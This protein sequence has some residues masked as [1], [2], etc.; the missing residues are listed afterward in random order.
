MFTRDTPVGA[1]IL[2]VWVFAPLIVVINKD[3]VS[4]ACVLYGP[5]GA[6]NDEETT[7]MSETPVLVGWRRCD[8][9]LP[10]KQPR[11]SQWVVDTL[12]RR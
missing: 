11:R 5:Y 6:G 3:A 2:L 4:L 1:T 8:N 10:R 9:E 12:S 7:R